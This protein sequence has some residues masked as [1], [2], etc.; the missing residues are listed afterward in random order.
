MQR[1]KTPPQALPPVEGREGTRRRLDQQFAAYSLS[2][3]SLFVRWEKLLAQFQGAVVM[4]AE[5]EYILNRR[6]TI[7]QNLPGRLVLIDSF[8]TQEQNH[9]PHLLHK[10]AQLLMAADVES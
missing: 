5:E 10:H 2:F 6:I 7:H 8:T 3:K 1:K 9:I 4:A